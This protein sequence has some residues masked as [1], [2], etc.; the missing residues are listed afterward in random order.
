MKLTEVSGWKGVARK[1]VCGGGGQH[2]SIETFMEVFCS[3]SDPLRVRRRTAL[4][5]FSRLARQRMRTDQNTL[6]DFGHFGQILPML[7]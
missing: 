4:P 3:S 5:P 6:V 2:L 1:S 7:A